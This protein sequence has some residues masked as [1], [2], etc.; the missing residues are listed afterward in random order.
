MAVW[1]M[2]A[3]A[4]TF[5]FKA[6]IHTHEYDGLTIYL[7]RNDVVRRDRETRIDSCRISNG[8]YSFSLPAPDSAFVATVAL[9]PKD[10]NFVY[11]LPEIRCIVEE[12]SVTADCDGYRLTLKGGRLNRE[13][14]DVYLSREREVRTTLERLMQ[15]RDS[16]ERKRPFT[17]AENNAY[18]E[19]VTALYAGL[20]PYLRQFISHNIGNNVGA[21]M[22][23]SYS[24]DYLSAAFMQE[25]RRKVNP[26]YVRQAE[27]RDREAR[28]AVET[29]DRNRRMTSAG[30]K[31]SDFKSKTTD[32][33]DVSL[34]QYVRPG[35]VTL[36]DFWASWCGP[37]LME[38]KELKRLYAEYHEKGF[39]IVGV[40]LDT[41]RNKWL[42]AI[43][44]HNLPWTHL[45][46]LQG[47]NDAGA[48]AYAVGAIPYVVLIDGEG[49]IVL[50]NMH[51]EP[52][53]KEIRRLMDDISSKTG[54]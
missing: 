23:F 21:Y 46:T 31:Y 44:Q 8:T 30:N 20:K 51:G 42:N 26:V 14:D 50:Q 25:M 36:L 35:R 4:Q 16:A 2:A 13:Y 28:E 29:A 39:D 47:F 34:S 40:S 54:R 5:D 22:L 53:H 52:L 32:G 49:N 38:A 10:K 37:C 9:P 12:G 19:K 7:L 43:K 3:G 33:R 24:D 18:S 11:G 17:E 6:D 45:S 27:E 15:Q 1:S 41:D 48:K